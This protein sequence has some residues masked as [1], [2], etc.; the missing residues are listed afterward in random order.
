MLRR[1]LLVSAVT[2]SLIAASVEARADD[3]PEALPF[4]DARTYFQA[5]GTNGIETFDLPSSVQADNG[6]GFN[7]RFG[8]RVD[9]HFAVEAAF[10]W[11]GGFGLKEAPLTGSVDVWTLGVNVKAYLLTD[12]VQPFLLL[13][14]GGLFVT[15]GNTIQNLR[16]NGSGFMGRF[17][18]GL[19][20]YVT[21][22]IGISVESAYV[23][24]T[25]RSGNYDNITIGWSLFYRF[26]NEDDE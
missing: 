6:L 2:A 9:P 8:K 4:A 25:G 18:A 14:M 10:D 17:G 7:L 1:A 5:G 12:R 11:I 22:R 23:L 13:G 19:D 3:E 26:G 15:G 16:D 24:P 20:V 21:E